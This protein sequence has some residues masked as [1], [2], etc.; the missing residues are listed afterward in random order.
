MAVAKKLPSY[1]GSVNDRAFNGKL[2][3][4]YTAGDPPITI[5]L[6][7]RKKAVVDTDYNRIIGLETS[8]A[9]FDIAPLTVSLSVLRPG[10]GGLPGHQL[11]AV[12]ALV[13]LAVA[14]VLAFATMSQRN[15]RDGTEY[16]LTVE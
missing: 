6:A 9:F 2:I 15:V 13:T 5:L 16:L 8:D 3:Q 11:L 12:V 4:K 7:H 10:E 14:A 1:F